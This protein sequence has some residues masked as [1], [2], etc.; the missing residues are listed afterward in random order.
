MAQR[1]SGLGR[2]VIAT[3]SSELRV[4]RA[5]Q[6]V[7]GVTWD[8]VDVRDEVSVATAIRRF[9]PTHIFNLAGISS[10]AASWAHPRNFV[11]VNTLGLL[12][13]LQTLLASN[14]LEC[15]VF[16]ATSS[17]IYGNQAA[18]ID[19]STLP[20]P[21]SPYAVSKL[22]SHEL[23]RIYRQVSGLFVCSGI[24]FNHESPL[25]PKNFVS[26][27]IS[28]QVAEIS[29][30]LRDRLTIGDLTSTR[31]WGWAPEYVTAIDLILQSNEPSD[32]VVATGIGHTVADM[33]EQAFLAIGVTDWKN[34]TTLDATFSRPNDVS[35]S[36]GNPGKISDALG[37]KATLELSKIME[38]MVNFDRALLNGV[39]EDVA[40]NLANSNRDNLGSY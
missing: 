22:A 33:V 32:Y 27:R 16:Q 15:R 25:R 3:G 18:P 31:D 28:H 10:V 1:L 36:I 11:D 9:A 40:L 30:G 24:L 29:M 20:K 5:R 8:I 14:N 17:E 37:W 13:I 7:P 19:E 23:V 4:G 26:R 34:L 39:A 21:L 12:N 35:S 38:I 6:L 2:E